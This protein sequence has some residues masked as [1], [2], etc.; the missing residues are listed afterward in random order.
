MR[1]IISI[2]AVYCIIMLA[3]PVVYA[4]FVDPGWGTRG[5]G[6]GGAFI[7]TADDASTVF[8][9]PAALSQ[10]FMREAM[11]SYHKPY[12]GLDGINMYRGYVSA[13]FPLE[14][15]ASFG[16]SATAYDVNSLYKENVYM[17]SAS[18][19]FN[20]KFPGYKPVLFSTGVNLKYLYH[21]Y[22]WDA[23]IKALGDP[24]T[25]KAGAGAF[26]VDIGFLAQP[27]YEFPIG[28][29]VKNVIRADVGLESED[30]VP[31][32][33]NLGAAY[34]MGSIGRFEE[35]TPELMI[36]YR[37]QDYSGEFR[38]ALG[39]EGWL[40][41]HTIGLRAGFNP[42]EVAAGASI[43]RYIGNIGL[44]IDY[45]AVISFA[46]RDNLGSHRVTTTVK[47]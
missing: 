6:K 47:F 28:V 10:I 1:K 11:F 8:W 20:M 27:R 37:A 13:V 9:N 19:Y 12:A 4:A 29:C 40:S 35:V 15:I 45:A 16:L 21:S 39:I 42:N 2:I 43:E 46:I 30:I 38:Y 18:K 14:G 31:M 17:L 34:R 44:R 24:I 7:A 33:V 22:N 23:E 41:L 5:A 3:K 25:D 26:S 36:G 32:E